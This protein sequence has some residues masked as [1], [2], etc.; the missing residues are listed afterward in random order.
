MAV[1]TFLQAISTFWRQHPAL[2]YG[3]AYLLGCAFALEFHAVYLLPCAVVWAPLWL[4][5]NKHS[6][7]LIR[8]L[9]ALLL[10]GAA[11]SYVALTIKFPDSIQ[12]KEFSG[13]AHFDID[14]FS[15]TS[16]HY[17]TAWRYTGKI[18]AFFVED[19][20][21]ASN[22]PA[23]IQLPS[24]LLP[25]EADRSYLIEGTLREIAPYRYVLMPS[26]DKPW[27][28]IARSYSLAKWRYQTKEVV[29][30]Y[31]RSH[32]Q[33]PH[34]AAFLV[35]IATGDFQDRLLTYEFSRFS[36]QHIMAIS[37]FHFAIVAGFLNFLL[38]LLFSG[39]KATYV[40]IFL[41]S[42]YFAFLGCAPSIMR[43]WISSILLLASTLI[44]RKS[45]GLNSLGVGLLV[46]LV[47]DP[48]TCTT[49]GFQFSFA[50]T[51]AILLVYPPTDALLQG[52]FPKRPLGLMI[53]M[54]EFSQ[55]AYT[56]LS[57]CR[58]AIAL[59]VAVNSVALPMTLF[60]FLKFPLM[61][62]FYNLFFPFM[63]SL[64]MTFL[65]IGSLVGMVFVPFGQVIHA[66]NEVY[67]RFML[68]YTYNMPTTLDAMWRVSSIST[69]VVVANLCAIFVVGLLAFSYGER[70]REEI[71]DWAFV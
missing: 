66:F 17:G 46:I 26:K 2:L 34:V 52:I 21:I 39:R 13:I 24:I 23:T 31:I 3:V 19:N 49:M 36:L 64:S 55:H 59:T 56:L 9:L 48:L 70:K 6:A 71:D 8:Q 32:F 44:E 41:L 67:T 51:A 45:K 42:T 30:T 62:F 4:Q 18:R 28:P 63:V 47:F 1:I 58:Q 14:S 57:W 29:A 10:M 20:L 50:A 53:R 33:D 16:K 25:A 35:G 38:S 60:Y 5:K 27:M 15:K 54:G 68:S 69:T 43:A 11:A 22:V 12:S 37:G 65:L 61:G 40:L 7:T